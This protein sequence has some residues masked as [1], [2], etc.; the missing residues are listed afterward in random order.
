M[1][2]FYHCRWLFHVKVSIIP[3]EQLFCEYLHPF[4]FSCVL[5]ISYFIKK[6]VKCQYLVLNFLRNDSNRE[7]LFG[8]TAK[9]VVA[10]KLRASEYSFQTYTI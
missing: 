3:L 2:I 4:C 6:L 1:N 7:I 5:R 9:E 8:W 10:L